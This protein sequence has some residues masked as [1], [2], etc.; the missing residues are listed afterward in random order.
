MNRQLKRFTALLDDLADVSHI[1]R[2]QIKLEACSHRTRQRRSA[3]RST[4]ANRRRGQRQLTLHLPQHPIYLHADATRLTQVFA[5]LLDNAYSATTATG[6]VSL[7]VAVDG[8]TVTVRVRDDGAGIA[9]ENLE[10]IFEMFLQTGDQRSDANSPS[11]SA[12]ASQE[13]WSS[14]TAER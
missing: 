2:G 4:A 5:H 1:T 9:D 7:S 10:R 3:T 14:C 8:T 11:A 6:Q 13:D 12:S